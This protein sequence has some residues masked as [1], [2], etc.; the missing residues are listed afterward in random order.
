MIGK[1][2]R[3][4]DFERVLGSQSRAR[5]V[6]FALHHLAADPAPDA[7][8]AAKLRTGS[9]ELSTGA[10]QAAH[11][12]VDRD[13]PR[14]PSGCWLGIVV[15]KRHARRSVTRQLL[16]RQIR[17]AFAERPG[18][19]PGLWVVRLRSPFD[20]QKFPS[21]ASDALRQAARA[22]LAQLLDRA[23]KPRHEPRPEA[24]A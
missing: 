15:P 10:A 5:S 23:L 11:N 19:P 7:W 9:A 13:S 18:M 12:A 14:A 22:E 16:K 8:H 1:L 2:Q 24:V 17:A 3:P 6:H 21:A 4:V 20:R